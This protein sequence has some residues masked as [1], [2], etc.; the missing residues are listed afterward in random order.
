MMSDKLDAVLQDWIFWPETNVR[1]QHI[2]N[3]P[4]TLLVSIDYPNVFYRKHNLVAIT[5]RCRRQGCLAQPQQ[6]KKQTMASFQW[7]KNTSVVID[8]CC[9]LLLRKIGVFCYPVGSQMLGVNWQQPSTSGNCC[10]NLFLAQ[11]FIISKGCQYYIMYNMQHCSFLDFCNKL[12]VQCI[13]D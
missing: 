4:F 3:T 7:L 10:R 2:C 6:L 13:N 1:Y 11:S 12:D 9:A 5:F 8:N